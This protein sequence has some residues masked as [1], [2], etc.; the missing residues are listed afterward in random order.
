MSGSVAIATSVGDTV[1]TSLVCQAEAAFT[2]GEPP[3]Y[4][5]S[6]VER[7]TSFPFPAKP[8]LEDRLV[9]PKLTEPNTNSWEPSMSRHPSSATAWMSPGNTGP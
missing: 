1:A 7:L 4:L 2:S 9:P 5:T 3:L 6:P 8:T